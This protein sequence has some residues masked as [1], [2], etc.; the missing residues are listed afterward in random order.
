MVMND[1]PPPSPQTPTPKTE[2]FGHIWTEFLVAIGYLTRFQ[3]IGKWETPSADIMRNAMAWFPIVGLVIGFVGATVDGVMA[4]LGLPPIITATLA[5]L[6]TLWLTRA[7]HEQQFGSF[8]NVYN[9]TQKDNVSQNIWIKEERTVQYGT[10]AVVVVIIL[11]IAVIASLN[12]SELVYAALIASASCSR[13]AM[14]AA[15][16]A[17]KPVPGDAE[18]DYCCPRGTGARLY[19]AECRDADCCCCRHYCN[20]ERSFCRLPPKKWLY[21]RL[22]GHDT[23]SG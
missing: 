18:S 2:N 8:V 11:K 10:I 6:A 23:T 15:A 14:V 13:A 16:V 12:S 19:G 7:L 1:M 5:I 22:A 20:T 3:F 17:L 21:R 9:N 4:L